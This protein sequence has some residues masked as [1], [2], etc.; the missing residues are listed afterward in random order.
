MSFSFP[1]VAGPLI[2][3]RSVYVAV[4]TMCKSDG[5]LRATSR[6]CSARG[7][8]EV[9]AARQLH[10]CDIDLGN[11]LLGMPFVAFLL[12]NPGVP[13]QGYIP[14]RTPYPLG[15]WVWVGLW[16]PGGLP[17]SFPN[18]PNLWVKPAPVCVV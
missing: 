18:R 10:W 11:H 3:I 16:T 15:V 12:A 6:A 13:A 4:V 9:E 8:D 2:D 14:L 7:V 5:I 17:L 1:S